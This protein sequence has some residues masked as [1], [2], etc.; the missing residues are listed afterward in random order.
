MTQEEAIVGA[1]CVNKKPPS[2]AVWEGQ[3]EAGEYPLAW[4]FVNALVAKLVFQHVTTINDLVPP[5]V[6]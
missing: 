2:V 5:T 6:S 3:L 4:M 1:V